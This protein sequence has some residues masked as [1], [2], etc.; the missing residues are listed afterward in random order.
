MTI[1]VLKNMHFDKVNL[2]SNDFVA[3][4]V[5]PHAFL[6]LAGAIRVKLSR[7]GAYSVSVLPIIHN[8]STNAGQTIAPAIADGS[9]YKIEEIAQDFTGSI[10]MSLIVDL[11]GASCNTDD[12]EQ[13]IRCGRFAGGHLNEGP[14][15][16]GSFEV[17][18]LKDWS[19]VDFQDI[20]PGHVFTPEA[21]PVS[22]GYRTGMVRVIEAMHSWIEAARE[23]GS[24]ETVT[25]IA[26]GFFRT[27][28]SSPALAQAR[29]GQK[30]HNFVESVTGLAKYIPSRSQSVTGLGPDLKD[31]AWRWWY[32][33]GSPYCLFSQHYAHSI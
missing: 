9:T 22:R 14:L 8:I 5:S 7:A 10:D 20:R 1:Y 26:A 18:R 3:G 17:A 27:N 15:T 12:I 21:G 33:K 28:R 31:L 6:G 25:T 2:F 23:H 19:Q 11:E 4:M 13:F 24:N 16:E 29:G 32:Q 30:P